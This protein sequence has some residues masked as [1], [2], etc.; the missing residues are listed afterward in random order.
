MAAGGGHNRILLAPGQDIRL[1]DVEPI[2]RDSWAPSSVAPDGQLNGWASPAISKPASAKAP[3]SM[4]GWYGS[5]ITT[6]IAAA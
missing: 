5:T 6:A 3:R 4:G 1:C 2:R